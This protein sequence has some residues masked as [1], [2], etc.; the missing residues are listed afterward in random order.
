MADQVGK[1]YR[2]EAG[3]VIGGLVV[4][5][6]KVAPATG[7]GRFGPFQIVVDGEPAH[8]QGIGDVLDRLSQREGPPLVEESHS[9]LFL[10]AVHGVAVN[11]QVG[12]SSLDQDVK[13]VVEV[14]ATQASDHLAFPDQWQV[15]GGDL[16]GFEQAGTQG[17]GHRGQCGNE[18]MNRSGHSATLARPLTLTKC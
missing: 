17:L 15:G 11:S 3:K 8:S 16:V 7:S 6:A 5:G 4:H 2:V 10:G 13:G 14:G 9:G 1:A 12:L 18:G